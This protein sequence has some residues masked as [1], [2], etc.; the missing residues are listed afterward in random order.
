MLICKVFAYWMILVK[1]F[2]FIRP[3]I[4]CSSPR[5]LANKTDHLS[6]TQAQESIS[7]SFHIF[8][9]STA[10]LWIWASPHFGVSN[11]K[12]WQL[13][14]GKVHE[15]VRQTEE[16]EVAEPR[17]LSRARFIVKTLILPVPFHRWENQNR[18][19]KKKIILM[20]GLANQAQTVWNWGLMLMLVVLW[21]QLH[22][23][24]GNFSSQVLYLYTY[25]NS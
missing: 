17:C 3:S 22:F 24:G 4:E 13:L 19:E 7:P 20:Y 16:T 6:L 10:L 14:E 21:G 8:P 25:W 12:T 2:L 1:L 18:C 15:N 11:F 9:F 5:Y 23:L